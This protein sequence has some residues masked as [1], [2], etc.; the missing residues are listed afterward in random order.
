M[1]HVAIF[2]D[3][4]LVVIGLVSSL[5]NYISYNDAD[6]YDSS[7]KKRIMINLGLS[8]STVIIGIGL[9]YNKYSPKNKFSFSG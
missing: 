8:I 4:L 5:L 1:K 2:V 3:V 6:S 9:L 7:L